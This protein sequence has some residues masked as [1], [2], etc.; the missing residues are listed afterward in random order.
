MRKFF[1]WVFI[2]S[3][4]LLASGAPAHRVVSLSPAL[5]ELVC[6]L[7]A[8][9]LLVGRS[10]GCNYPESVQKLP[11]AGDFGQPELERVLALKPDWVIANDFLNPGV[12]RALRQS[13][14]AVDLAQCRSLADYRKWVQLIGNR[15]DRRA[16]AHREMA[17]VDEF[18]Q[19]MAR[20]PPLVLNVLWVVWDSPLMVAGPGS[21]PDYALRTVKVRNRAAQA[22]NE[23][24]KCSLE[25]VLAHPPDVIVWGPPGAPDAR[26]RFWGQLAAVR[27]NRVV[28]DLDDDLILRPGPRW[29]TGLRQLRKTLEKF[30]EPESKQ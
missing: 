22:G 30:A 28:R 16:A 10:T 11:T 7:D 25:W 14:V 15:L 18:E 23:Y 3:L 13:G 26:H 2:G 1:S 19:Q 6:A 29:P 9:P 17:E 4:A 21:L 24:F 20:L 12:A 8:E 5:T 27:E